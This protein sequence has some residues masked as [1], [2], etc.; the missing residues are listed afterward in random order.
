MIYTI[1]SQLENFVLMVLQAQ[2]MG[3][4]S[5][6][7]VWKAIRHAVPGGMAFTDKI[8]CFSDI[9]LT[10]LSQIYYNIIGFKEA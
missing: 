9:S 7:G 1:K 2:T 6:G 8:R 3:A 4:G 10:I 5:V